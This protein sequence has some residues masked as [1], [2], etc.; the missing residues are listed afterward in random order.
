MA[1]GYIPTARM[2]HVATCMHTDRQDKPEQDACHSANYYKD[3]KELEHLCW[4]RCGGFLLL[5]EWSHQI[6]MLQTEARKC[7]ENVDEDRYNN[8]KA[9]GAFAES[10]ETPTKWRSLRHARS[11]STQVPLHSWLDHV[12][13]YQ[14]DRFAE[15]SLC[16]GWWKRAHGDDLR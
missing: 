7:E 8:D 10:D 16:N 5:Q 4:E 11:S 3:L 1:A 12:C 2:V 9:M 13:N 14:E 6:G 15:Y